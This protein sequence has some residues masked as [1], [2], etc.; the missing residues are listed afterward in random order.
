M[1]VCKIFEWDAA[2][3]LLLDYDSKCNSLHGHT[4]KV[5]FLFEGPVNKNS[6]M[7]I[8]FTFI[9]EYINTACS[10]DHQYLN[11]L[12][13]QPTAE[14]I[15]NYLWKKI[16]RDSNLNIMTHGQWKERVSLR[17]IRVWET[18]TSYAEEEWSE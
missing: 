12:I 1:R 5:E 4:Y 16:E 17:K 13:N 7:V 8:D 3:K 11:D 10:F 14:N 15:V 9:K 6:G 18:P 2:H